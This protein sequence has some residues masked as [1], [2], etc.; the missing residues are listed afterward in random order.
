MKMLLIKDNEKISLFII[1]GMNK[2]GFL[3]AHIDNGDQ[4][5][6]IALAVKYDVAIIDIM[7]PGHN[8]L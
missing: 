2:T 5:L 7:S 8:D 1:R 6:S 4:K 3:M